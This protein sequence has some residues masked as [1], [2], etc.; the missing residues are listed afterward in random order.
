MS[1]RGAMRTSTSGRIRHDV[2]GAAFRRR[3]TRSSGDFCVDRLGSPRRA[4][5]LRAGMQG[6][7]K[8]TCAS[9]HTFSFAQP[10]V[11]KGFLR[12]PMRLDRSACPSMALPVRRRSALPREA[13]LTP[14]ARRILPKQMSQSVHVPL[15]GAIEIVSRHED[16]QLSQ[17]PSASER[18]QYPSSAPRNTELAPGTAEPGEKCAL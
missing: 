3:S 12:G 7:A 11:W 2:P 4:P 1:V 15:S 14:S 10:Q 13:E 6:C 17:G 5:P 8:A 18:R 9:R 16:K